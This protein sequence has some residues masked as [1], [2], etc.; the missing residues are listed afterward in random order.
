MPTTASVRKRQ[1]TRPVRLQELTGRPIGD[2]TQNTR[3]VERRNLDACLSRA[4]SGVV[5]R[6]IQHVFN[7]GHFAL[8]RRNVRTICGNVRRVGFNVRR[9]SCD[10]RG[11]GGYV[12]HVVRRYSRNLNE[13][14]LIICYARGVGGNVRRVGCGVISN[15][16]Q[17]C[18]RRH[19]NQ[20]GFV[21]DVRNGSRVRC[22]RQRI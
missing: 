9:V 17:I 19:R 22:R 11:V 2:R 13:S 16:I 20:I 1:N 21:L 5:V 8:Q 15:R 7:R 14:R 12:C 4:G 6:F 3:R 18:G 10:V